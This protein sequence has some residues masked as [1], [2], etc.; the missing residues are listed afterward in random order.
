MCVFVRYQ[1]VD[2]EI[3]EYQTENRRHRGGDGQIALKVVL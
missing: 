3:V 1:P 2:Q